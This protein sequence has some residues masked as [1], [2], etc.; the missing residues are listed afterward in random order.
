MSCIHAVGQATQ[1]R[2]DIFSMT[3]KGRKAG[4]KHIGDIRDIGH[5]TAKSGR[6]CRAGI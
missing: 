6:L 1:P 3:N 5:K 4:K 2:R